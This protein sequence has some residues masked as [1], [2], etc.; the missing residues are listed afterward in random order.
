MLSCVLSLSFLFISINLWQTPKATLEIKE[1]GVDT[2]KD[3]GS[4][5]SMYLKLQILPIVIHLGE[6]H[7][8]CENLCSSKGSESLSIGNGSTIEK[9]S[10]HFI[11]DEFGLLLEFGSHRFVFSE[12]FQIPKDISILESYIMFT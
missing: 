5:P 11:C 4:K 2:Y 3:R 7:L 1:L 9:S 8:S 6:P 10:A 12:F